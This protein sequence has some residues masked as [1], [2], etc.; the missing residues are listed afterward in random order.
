MNEVGSIHKR[1]GLERAWKHRSWD[2]RIA[3]HFKAHELP[4]VAKEKILGHEVYIGVSDEK[5]WDEMVKYPSGY[6]KTAYAIKKDK[7]FAVQILEFDGN[8]DPELTEHTKLQARVNKTVNEAVDSIKLGIE[9]GMY[10]K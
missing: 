4:R 7:T 1:S 5:Q 10:E 9:G 6:Y 3:Q 8:H 2:E